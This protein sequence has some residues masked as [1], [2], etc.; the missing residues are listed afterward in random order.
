MGFIHGFL[1][2]SSLRCCYP[3]LG[4]GAELYLTLQPERCHDGHRQQIGRPAEAFSEGA[5]ARAAP[6]LGAVS[7][8]GFRLPSPECN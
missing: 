5:Q 3:R 1:S 7:V 4:H 2:S 8:R 6:N